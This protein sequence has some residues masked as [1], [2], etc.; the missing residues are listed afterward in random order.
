MSGKLRYS[1]LHAKLQELSFDIDGSAEAKLGLTLEVKAP[2][3][4]TF[5]YDPTPLT[6]SLVNVPGIISL[7]PAL[8][9]KIGAD[10]GA[11]A[12]LTVT[13]DLSS[14]I[15]NGKFHIDFLDSS[16]SSVTGITPTFSAVTNITE[17]AA[18]SIDPFV[19]ITVELAFLLLG[20]LV[21]LSGGVTAQPRFNNDFVLSATQSLDGENDTLTQP[22]GDGCTQGLSITSEF[23][24]SVI[25]FVT[26]WWKKT[27]YTVTKPIANECYTW[28]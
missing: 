24:F 27:V 26:Q 18:V 23:E 16:A 28:L 6:Y 2:Y 19:D 8:S 13:T 1:I 17:K 5:S 4:H 10:L 7:G 11:E 15:E 9:F 22:Q 12:G 21:D 20:G 3:K 14:K 25:A